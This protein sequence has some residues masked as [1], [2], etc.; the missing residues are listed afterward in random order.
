MRA[1]GRERCDVPLS[2][3]YDPDRRFLATDFP[4]VND[5]SLKQH[6]PWSS[7]LQF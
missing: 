2:V 3:K 4:T 7:A 5:E 6:L 1:Q